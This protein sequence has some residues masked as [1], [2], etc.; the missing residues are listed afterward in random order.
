MLVFLH[1]SDLHRSGNRP[2]NNDDLLSA[3]ITDQERFL[4]GSVGVDRLSAI[5]VSG[6]LVHGLP[7]GSPDYAGGLR[8]QYNEA[9][10]FLSRL[11]DAL[12]G[13]NRARVIVVPGNHD[14]DFN[15]SA[16]AMTLVDPIPDVDLYEQLAAPDSPYRWCWKTRRLFRISDKAAYSGRLDQFAHFHREFYHGAPLA[17]PLDPY[18]GHNWYGLNDGEILVAAFNSCENNDCYNHSGEIADGEISRSHL[19]RPCPRVRCRL[20]MAIWH[21][22][23]EGPPLRTDYMS[24]EVVPLLIDRGFQLGLHG[25]HHKSEFRPA[26]IRISGE[27]RMAIVSA[28]SLAGGDECL[29]AGVNRQYNIIRINDDFATGELFVREMAVRGIFGEGRLAAFGGSSTCHLDWSPCVLPAMPAAAAVP[30]VEHIEQLLRAREY[31]AAFDVLSSAVIP[32]QYKRQLMLEALRG[33]ER[34]QDIIDR[35]SPPTTIGELTAV[36]DAA[37]NERQ[38]DVGSA[39][40]DRAASQGEFPELLLR[41]LRERIGAEQAIRTSATM[42]S[43]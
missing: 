3:I 17:Y 27:R 35:L 37:I 40:L 18:R 19:A 15:Q 4:P 5:V 24:A 7:L 12:L 11:T 26:A 33:A 20:L 1:I 41:Q 39:V 42:R 22:D 28:G 36:I 13:G 38:W 2:I 43:R 9:R 14:M 29:P 6:D 8:Q 31:S 16:R 10:E 32:S 25:H 34:W 30:A 23:I 21:H